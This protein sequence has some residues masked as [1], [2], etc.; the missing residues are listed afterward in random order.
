[1]TA[2][3]TCYLSLFFWVK[4]RGVFVFSVAYTLIVFGFE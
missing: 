1:M 3:F 2:S 4:L